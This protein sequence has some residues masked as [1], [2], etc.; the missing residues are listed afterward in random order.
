MCV[1]LCR[2]NQKDRD[3]KPTLS[4]CYTNNGTFKAT[5][6]CTEDV[7]VC[8]C[9]RNEKDRDLKPTLHTVIPIMEHLKP[10]T[11]AQRMCVCVCA[12]GIRRTET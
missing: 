6:W 5:H 10:P 2:R 3:L 7:C 11:G 9:R 4:H 1:C 12:D 8:L